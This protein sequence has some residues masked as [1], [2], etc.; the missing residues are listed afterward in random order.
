MAV[1]DGL[2]WVGAGPADTGHRGG[3]LTVLA[4]G[5]ADT[6][7]PLLTQNLYTSCRWPTTG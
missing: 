2:V 4:T 7:D 5:Y 6:M 1:A 3:T